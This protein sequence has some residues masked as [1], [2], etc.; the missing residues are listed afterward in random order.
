LN[1]NEPLG[2]LRLV[3]LFVRI[4]LATFRFHLR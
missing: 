4:A 2:S 1:R 3:M